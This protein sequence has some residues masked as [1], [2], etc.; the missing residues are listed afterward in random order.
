LIKSIKSIMFVVALLLASTLVLL[1]CQKGGTMTAITVT[2]ADTVMAK[3]TTQQFTA[4]ELFSSGLSMNTIYC[5]WSSSNPAVATVDASG[6]VTAIAAGTTDIIATNDSNKITG[7]ATLTVADP[8]SITVTPYSPRMAVG[9][10]HVFSAVAT[11]PPGNITQTVTQWVSWNSSDTSVAT[12]GANGLVTA[13]SMTGTAIITA[14]DL[15]SNLSGSTLVTVSTTTL[16]A[17]TVTPANPTLSLSAGTTQQFSAT[18]TYADNSSLDLTAALLWSSSI[19]SVATI[20][21][22]PGSVANGLA[23][24]SAA[25][26]TTITALDPI[27]L[28]AGST[29]LTV[30]P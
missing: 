19:T 3:G 25:G 6:L 8:L 23:T 2:P 20:S 15:F 27:T 17:I 21:S 10:T 13:G 5:T 1:G 4:T 12:V 30:T 29:I 11:L 14:N 7:A 28:N 16:T 18:G 9:T 26:A 22:S 24:L